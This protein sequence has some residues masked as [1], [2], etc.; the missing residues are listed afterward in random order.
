MAAT[1]VSRNEAAATATGRVYEGI[2][3]AIVEHRLSP[4]LRLR[5]EE[6]AESFGVSRTVVRQAL[7][8][9]A[10]DQ[11]V[12]LQHN[13][14]A[15]VPHPDIAQAASVF[16]ARRVIECEIARK[17]AGHLGPE[18]VANLQAL[19]QAEAEAHSRG[20]T[21]GAVRLSGRFHRDLAVLAGNAVFVRLIDELLPIT[22][23]LI[24]L[25]Q[26][27]G[28]PGCVTHSHDALI[29][30][31]VEGT[32]A[33]AAAEMRRHLLELERSLERSPTPAPLR[34]VFAPYRESPPD[35]ESAGD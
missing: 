26:R 14:G 25:Y 21:A 32:P 35:A 12:E 29:Q 5:E 24:V 19:V 30:A 8:R 13:R 28:H 31:L 4:G 27:R 15:Q 16:E 10:A 22:S 34:D 33:R 7:Q 11:V 6:L 1:R 23:L 18:Q 9:L 2:Y 17:L 20:D 3:Q